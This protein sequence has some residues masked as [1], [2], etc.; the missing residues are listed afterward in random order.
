MTRAL[1]SAIL[2]RFGLLPLLVAVEDKED[3]FRALM[4]VSFD[5][6]YYIS[7]SH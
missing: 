4:A 2:L 3:Y 7:Y 6:I 5:R 1:V